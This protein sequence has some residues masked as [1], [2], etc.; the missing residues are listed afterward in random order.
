MSPQSPIEELDKKCRNRKQSEEALQ[1]SLELFRLLVD[2]MLDTVLIIDWEGCVLFV[3]RAGARLVGFE[4][5]QQ[6]LGQNIVR[7]VHPD[8]M[9]KVLKDLALVKQGKAGFI[10]EYRII[11][12]AGEQKW[13]EARGNKIKFRGSSA[14]LIILRDV[15]ERK[16]ADE[17]RK[18]LELQFQRAQKLEA[19]GTL[20]GGIAHD[21]NNL[22]MTIQG[23]ASLILHDMDPDHPNFKLLKNIETSVL[24]GARLTTQLLGYAQKGKYQVRPLDLNKLVEET[25]AALSRTKREITIHRKLSDN[26]SD[27]LADKGQIEQVL[28]NLCVNAI[29]AM[30]EGGD[31]ILET[32]NVTHEDLQGKLYVPKPG[33]YV[34]LTVNDTGIG[35]DK[36]TLDRIFEPFFTTK[37]MGKGTGL[38]LAAVYGIIKGHSGYIEVESEAGRG[39]TFH[40]FLPA[41]MQKSPDSV[42]PD[43]VDPAAVFGGTILIVD[44]EDLVLEVG[45]QLLKKLGYSVL[46]AKSG[47]DALRI[48][49]ENKNRIRM[50]ILDMIMP[51]MG[52]GE[53]YDRMRAI[54]PNVRVLLSSGYSLDGQA[55]K[56]LDRG[57]RAFIQKPFT[58]QA[59]S[60]KISEVITST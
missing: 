36:K 12:L 51:G 37:E 2:N 50:V 21:F 19:I 9:E 3:N 22:L 25:A 46:E 44:D 20:A 30:P 33:N 43:S 34:K 7:F 23:N 42:K 56:I 45:V 58:L 31:L 18:Q 17:E 40:I 53:T 10:A 14:D 48:Y 5:P 16:Q 1:E 11:T 6:G 13:I 60:A 15:T 41:L 27:I 38:G 59:L 39:T 54:H 47:K 32:Q 28:L 55:K 26:L 29:D 49:A 8:S 35:M 24:N 4:S 57:C 52:G